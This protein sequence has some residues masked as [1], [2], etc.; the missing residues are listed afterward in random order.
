MQEGLSRYERNA[1]RVDFRGP[2]TNLAVAVAAAI[3]SEP[4]AAN[5]PVDWYSWPTMSVPADPTP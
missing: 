5:E 3:A 1:G 4:A 2:E